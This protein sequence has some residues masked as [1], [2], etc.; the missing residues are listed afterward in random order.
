MNPAMPTVFSKF[1]LYSEAGFYAA[2]TTTLVYAISRKVLQVAAARFAWIR[3][4]VDSVAFWLTASVLPTCYRLAIGGNPELLG[5]AGCAHLAAIALI[6]IVSYLPTLLEQADASQN[7]KTSLIKDLTLSGHTYAPLP[8]RDDILAAIEQ[9]LHRAPGM[10]NV[11]LIGDPISQIEWIIQECA[12]RICTS[13]SNSPFANKK[14]YRLPIGRILGMSATEL[15]KEFRALSQHNQEIILVMD[16]LALLETQNLTWHSEMIKTCI[17][18]GKISLIGIIT[19]NE[20]V[21]MQSLIASW[22]L[23]TISV[24]PMSGADCLQL[25]KTKNERGELNEGH[26]NVTIT[27]NALA[28]ATLLSYRHIAK[29]FSAQDAITTL[30]DALFSIHDKKQ[31]EL[32][33]DLLWEKWEKSYQL[34]SRRISLNSLS[35]EDK[36]F[37]TSQGIAVQTITDQILELNKQKKHSSLNQAD[38]P[39]YLRDMNEEAREKRFRRCIGREEEI[40]SIITSLR[41]AGTKNAILLGPPGIGKTAIF[42]EI[43]CL[44]VDSHP[45]VAFLKDKVFYW[46]D[47]NALSATDRYVGTFEKKMEGFMN[48]AKARSGEAIFIMDELHQLQGKGTYQGHR[49]DAFEILKSNLGRSD[50]IIVLGTSNDYKWK[51]VLAGDAALQRRFNEIH[52]APPTPD[53]CLQMLQ[54]VLK[55]GFYT[56][57]FS[58][59]LVE[60]QPASLKAAIDLTQKYQTKD[61][62]PD[63]ATVLISRTIAHYQGIQEKNGSSSSHSSQSKMAITPMAITPKE[64]ATC[65]YHSIKHALPPSLSEEQFLRQ[66]KIS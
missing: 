24:K 63:K 25:L 48:F 18:S 5:V 53:L 46:V 14:I 56:K 20:K 36:K 8:G 42:E 34:D 37:F 21:Q 3:E 9:A 61:H 1:G 49:T 15:Q 32:N 55:T 6:G 58:N 13:T 23:A 35:E 38:I 54:Y 28:L 43:A 2:A 65:L 30:R 66:N 41:Q 57:G 27:D 60:L 51:E 64:I 31:V 7:S 22:N 33:K 45:S 16:Q 12:R 52:V 19:P 44:I 39:N 26:S 10:R 59:P 29:G 47:L 17:D 4:Y 11:L 50:D 40:Q 62:L